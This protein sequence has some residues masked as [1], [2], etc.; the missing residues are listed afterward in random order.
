ML[1]A[2]GV[3][4]Q[5]KTVSTQPEAE[6]L[7]LGNSSLSG[8]IG[9]AISSSGIAPRYVEKARHCSAFLFSSG[10]MDSQIII[11]DM[12]GW[13]SPDEMIRIQA[14]E[15]IRNCQEKK[16][17]PRGF[18]APIFWPFLFRAMTEFIFW[19]LK[20]HFELIRNENNEY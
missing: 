17:L 1:H 13:I 4:E 6:A 9:F 19:L 11:G 12:G 2:K 20:K 5:L 10:A 14:G 16:I 18:I 7:I 3:G 8:V 15:A